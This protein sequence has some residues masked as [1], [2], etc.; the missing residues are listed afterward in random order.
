[1]VS[2]E[3]LFKVLSK[4]FCADCES[5]ETGCIYVAEGRGTI[6][7]VFDAVRAAC[8]DNPFVIRIAGKFMLCSKCGERGMAPPPAPFN[9]SVQPFLVCLN[10]GAPVWRDAEGGMVYDPFLAGKEPEIV[11]IG[12]ELK[13]RVL[14]HRPPEQVI[15]EGLEKGLRFDG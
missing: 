14:C 6:C 12:G 9:A 7:P 10:C 5:V 1:M 11:E 4:S 3:D 2:Q 8:P 15:V 13:I